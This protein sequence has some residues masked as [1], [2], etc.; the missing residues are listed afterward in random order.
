MAIRLML[1]SPELTVAPMNSVGAALV[2]ALLLPSVAA[3]QSTKVKENSALLQDEEKQ[4]K[5]IYGWVDAK[6][7]WHYVDSLEL[8]PSAYQAQA[9]RNAIRATPGNTTVAANPN[10][11]T[12]DLAPAASRSTGSSNRRSLSST[13]DSGT[14]A[15]QRSMTDDER[16]TRIRQLQQR[17]GALEAEIAALEEGNA[18]ESYAKAAGSDDALTDEKLGQLLTQTESDLADAEAELASLNGS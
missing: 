7:A 2:L 18:P 16:T 3:A 13:N 17:I 11:A 6:G 9:K 12:T 4:E 10:P 5:K 15:T 14:L 8:V 1:L